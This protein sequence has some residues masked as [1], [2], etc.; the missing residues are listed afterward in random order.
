MNFVLAKIKIALVFG[1]KENRLGFSTF[2]VGITPTG[3]K[4]GNSL[5]CQPI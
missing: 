2:K 4:E 3:T 5:V 1:T